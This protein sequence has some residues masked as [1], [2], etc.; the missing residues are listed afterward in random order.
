MRTPTNPDPPGAPPG[1][2][3]DSLINAI[4]RVGSP[5]C[6]GIDPVYENLPP[7]LTASH[8][9]P[10]AA[11]FEFTH[12]VLAAAAEAVA[13]V[14]FQSACFERYGHEGIAALEQAVAEAVRLGLFVILDAKR[15]DIGSTSDHYA[16]AVRRMGAHAV[17]VN[18]YLGPS[19]V[20]PFVGTGLGVFVLVRTSNPDSD[21][22]QSA[23][24]ADGR[25]VAQVVAGQVAHLGRE[26]IGSR[27]LAGVGAV[28]GA[29]KSAEGSSLRSIMPDQM[30][31]VPGYGAQGGTA[32]DVRALTRKNARSIG[33]AGVVVNAS[34]SVI[35]A[36]S[37]ETN[38]RVRIHEAALAFARDVARIVAC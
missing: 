26:T 31:L 1:H 2:A 34:R 23:R 32:D 19:G 13:A 11:L 29:T 14:K 36:G 33:Q 37:G 3:I 16:A 27:G 9:T 21:E 25:T 18:G 7:A 6:V 28:V 30:F 5:A 10:T 12:S 35:Y 24:V 8:A 22:L 4:D 38:W 20:R 15:G 17:T